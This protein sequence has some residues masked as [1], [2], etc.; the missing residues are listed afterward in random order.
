[1]KFTYQIY[2]EEYILDGIPYIGYGIKIMDSVG[3][4]ILSIPDIST[5]KEQTEK[6]ATL[7]NTLSLSPPQIYDVIEEYFD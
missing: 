3:T 2:S 7:C 5:K 4:P 1:M 6:F